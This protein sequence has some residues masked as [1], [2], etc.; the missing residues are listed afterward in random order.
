MVELQIYR[1]VDLV[2]RSDPVAHSFVRIFFKQS[3]VKVGFVSSSEA[4]GV[5]GRVRDASA[6]LK[7]ADLGVLMVVA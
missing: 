5:V 6:G 2:K 3:P 4:F 7:G 1:S